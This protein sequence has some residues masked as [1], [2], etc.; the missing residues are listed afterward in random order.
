MFAYC[1]SSYF[2]IAPPSLLHAAISRPAHPFR[3]EISRDFGPVRTHTGATLLQSGA[4]PPFLPSPPRR[5]LPMDTKAMLHCRG[6]TRWTPSSRV[7]GQNLAEAAMGGR[8]AGQ[9]MQE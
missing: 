6:Q 1:T 7:S 8:A 3:H 2:A 9:Q 4:L 5:L